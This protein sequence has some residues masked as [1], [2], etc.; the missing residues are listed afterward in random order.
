MLNCDKFQIGEIVD[1]CDDDG[2][3]W[4]TTRITFCGPKGAT[5]EKYDDEVIPLEDIRFTETACRYINAKNPNKSFSECV[6]Q[7][8]VPL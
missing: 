6:Q 3:H 2:D 8:R 4:E 1:V 7:N 5:V